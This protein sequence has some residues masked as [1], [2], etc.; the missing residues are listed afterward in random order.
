LALP[1]ANF[2]F[3]VNNLDVQFTDTSSG[4]DINAWTWDF[5]DGTTSDEQNPAHTYQT[6]GTF[7]VTLT[8]ANEAGPATVSK[9][10]VTTAPVPNAP[11]SAFTFAAQD[12]TVQFTDMSTGDG[13]SAWRW[14]FGDGSESTDRNPS[15]TYAEAGTFRVRLTVTN[16]GGED[17]S[18]QDVT[19]TAPPPTPPVSNFTFTVNNL[20]VSFTDASAGVVESR[21]WD[22]GDGTTSVEANPTH[23]YAQAGTYPVTLTVI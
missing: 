21:Q 18:G 4:Q 14:E 22:F 2:D 11:T 3:E 12:L 16:P 13:I 23:S 20:D 10:V 1:V 6:A 9:D 19:V 5:G 15:H 7:N 8:V 17:R